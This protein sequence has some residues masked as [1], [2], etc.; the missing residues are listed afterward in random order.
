MAP[1]GPPRSGQRRQRV[2]RDRVHQPP[3]CAESAVAGARSDAIRYASPPRHG[4]RAG[5]AASQRGSPGALEGPHA[6]AG[7]RHVLRRPEAGPVPAHPG[8]GG[9]R[10]RRSDALIRAVPGGPARRRLG[11][12]GAFETERGAFRRRRSRT[13]QKRVVVRHGANAR[14]RR[15]RSVS[16]RRRASA[17]AGRRRVEGFGGRGERRVCGVSAQP[18][19][20]RQDA[21]HGARRENKKR[22][23]CI[24]RGGHRSRA[25]RERFM[26][27][28]RHVDDALGGAHRVA[29]RGVRLGQIVRARLAARRG[30]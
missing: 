25:R 22:F 12:D 15:R 18:H 30:G 4:R 1:S 19:R 7:A 23:R 21:P 14:D 20:A 29:V 27:R 5:S 28:R 8:G 17:V 11:G 3:G 6:L 10:A 16:V 24:V 9:I 2:V 13:K 26:A